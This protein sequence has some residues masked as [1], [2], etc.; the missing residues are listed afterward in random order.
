MRIIS[1]NLNGL[2]SCVEHGSFRPISELAPDVMCCQ[3]IRT[4]QQA[5]VLPG[6]QHFWN[7]SERDGYSG[8]LTMTRRSPLKVT[9]GLC[10][11]ELD[12]EGRVQIIEYPHLFI[13]NAY[14]PNSQKNLMRRQFRA[15]W[16]EAFRERVCELS[17]EK[18]VIACGD[19]NVTLSDIDI[20]PENLRQY[21]AQQG[22]ASD[23]RSNLETLME[24]GFTD[25]FR[26]LYPEATGTYT[27]WSNRRNKRDENRG[28][29]LDYFF[30]SDG[31]L[32]HVQG[33]EASHWHHGLRPL[34][35]TSGVSR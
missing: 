21:W 4:K 22:Y 7:P 14:A 26:H 12:A 35:D 15:Q 3:E 1:W 10:V 6:Y 17:E 30:V 5:E 31:V 32:L 20:Y 27:W 24:R 16:D 8:T 11:P 34:P 33:C 28:W 18:P 9:A 2:L 23:E 19:F 29:R 13:V 25:A